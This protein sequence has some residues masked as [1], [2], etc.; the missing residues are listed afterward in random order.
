MNLDE[1][2]NWHDFKRRFKRPPNI[3][4]ARN[5]VSAGVWPGRVDSDGEVWI[6]SVRYD[7]QRPAPDYI[8]A[9]A[10]QLTGT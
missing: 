10:L 8:D 7:L 3:R 1:L 2:E 5:K 9:L 6:Y 4:T